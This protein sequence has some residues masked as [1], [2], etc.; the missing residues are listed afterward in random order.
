MEHI[1]IVNTKK[2]HFK[3]SNT[4]KNVFAEALKLKDCAS[5][6]PDLSYPLK[7]LKKSDIIAISRMSN[8]FFFYI[9]NAGKSNEKYRKREE[10]M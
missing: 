3:Y 5:I 1:H 10:K 4:F 8:T 7:I 6:P 9:S 2:N